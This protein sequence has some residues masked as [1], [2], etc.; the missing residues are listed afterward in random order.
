MQFSRC[1]SVC[2]NVTRLK[3][4]FSSFDDV[5]LTHNCVSFL[6]SAD[7]KMTFNLSVTVSLLTGKEQLMRSI[8]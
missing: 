6:I 7:L 3:T 8:T 5:F 2:R 4:P 1:Y